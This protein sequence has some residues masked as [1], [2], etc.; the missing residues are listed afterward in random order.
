MGHAFDYIDKIEKYSENTEAYTDIAIWTSHTDS[1]L[2]CSK[3]LQIMHLEYDVVESGDDLSKYQCVILPDAV[4]LTEGDK[5]ALVAYA[6]NGG[7]LVVSGKSIFPELGFECLGESEYDL[8]YIKCDIDEVTTP[9][10]AYSHAYKVKAE[11]EVMAE[12]Y[13]PFFNR[14]WRHFCG[15][16]N[17]PNKAEPAEYPALIRKGNVLYFAHPVFEAYN[18]SGNYVLQKYIMKGIES[19]YDKCLK[20]S[21]FYSCGRVRVRKS[22]NDSFYALHLLYAPPVNR[23]NV[24]LLEDFPLLNNINVELKLTEQVKRVVSKPDGEEIPF[25]QANGILK[26]TVNNLHIHKLVVIEY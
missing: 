3:L 19:I 21:N 16:K 1:D 12:V 2:G 20:L 18:K 24:C 13:E 15:H 22:K 8:D 5:K 14:T 17:T 11:G 23:G 25:T 4:K 6:N 10:L 7:K 26:F 9:F